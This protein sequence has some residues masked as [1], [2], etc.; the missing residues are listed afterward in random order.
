M[1]DH[2]I[3][4]LGV[5]Q[6]GRLQ[7]R[8][9]GHDLERP[10][11]DRQREEQGMVVVERPAVLACEGR[12]DAAVEPPQGQPHLVGQLQ[13]QRRGRHPA[14]AADDQGDDRQVRGQADGAGAGA[15][16]RLVVL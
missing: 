14:Q 5:E 6:R 2:P 4:Q 15:L 16:E 13:P 7:D 12:G 11:Q 9:N 1:Q 10:V 8:P 3:G